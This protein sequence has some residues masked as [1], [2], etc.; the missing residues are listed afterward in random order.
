MKRGFQGVFA[1]IVAG[2]L[3]FGSPAARAADESES[4]GVTADTIVLGTTN[5]LT[6][7]VA[8]ACKPVSDGAVAWFEHVNATGGVN[9][10]KID[11]IVLDDQYTA[12]QALANARQLAEKP[13]LAFFG[14]CGTIQVPAILQVAK[15]EGVPYLF[16]YAGL[17]QLLTEPNVRLLL[18]LY[19]TQFKALVPS[20]LKQHGPGS[21][22]VVMQQVPGAQQ[23]EQSTE[24]AV[25]SAG[26]TVAG[27]A[28]TTAGQS[29]QT[30]LVLKIK[31]AAPDYVVMAEAA[32]DAA[33]IF[34][35]MQS[36]EGFP[37]K[38]VI[39]Q[40]TMTTGAF[41]DPVGSAANGHMLALSPVAPATSQ[42][43]QPCVDVLKAKGITPEGFALFGCATA[44]VMAEALKETG[45][46]LARASLL[47][48]FD[49][50]SNKNVSGLLPP[51]SFAPGSNL[52]ERSMILVG[53][54]DGKFVEQG[55]VPLQ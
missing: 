46:N 35:V 13:V 18:P 17:Q 39:G 3:V 19:E 34:K 12:Q 8:S 36:Q 32:P 31:E 21:V 51:L 38:F 1:F 2:A 22:F 43:A 45:R 40:S 23:T 37:K 14:G 50:W 29:D 30:P 26:G 49:S 4:P 20:V 5:P 52:G 11:D 24:A 28:Y 10:R 27:S 53:V 41:I 55:T 6:G 42:G 16:P 25:K 7:T 33:R 48:T 9:G 44:Q 15:K 54:V 47:K